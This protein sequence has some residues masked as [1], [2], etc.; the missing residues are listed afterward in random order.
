MDDDKALTLVIED[1]KM[2]LGEDETQSFLKKRKESYGN[3]EGNAGG[4]QG[5]GRG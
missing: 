2:S 4:S 1:R 5:C 3:A